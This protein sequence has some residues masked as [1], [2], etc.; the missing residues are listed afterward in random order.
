[1]SNKLLAIT[2]LILLAVIA[3]V[4]Y[5]KSAEE[6]AETPVAA[7]ALSFICENNQH[8]IGE[9][10]I[11]F[12]TLSV[13]ENGEVTRQVPRTDE[14][15]MR[16]SNNDFEYTFAGEGVSVLNKSSNEE[17]HCHQPLD[18]NN[19]PYN[20][21]DLGEGAGEEQ[22]VIVAIN[23]NI[24]GT[25]V[26]LDDEKF[27][28]EF[29]S[30]GTVVDRYEGKD[31]SSGPYT[32]FDSETGISTEFPQDEERI[33]IQIEDVDPQGVMY[34]SLVK[35]TPEELELIYMDGGGILRFSRSE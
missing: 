19:A 18:P 1:M 30:D 4:V 28:R 5:T 20:F 27:E 2:L 13:V 16:F 23:E 17:T 31:T 35:L 29:R 26:S 24:A 9:F 32:V 22:N 25:W 7:V 34:F 8:F 21:G 11:D 15:I 33:Y 3:V 6:V 10:D 14:V 12:E